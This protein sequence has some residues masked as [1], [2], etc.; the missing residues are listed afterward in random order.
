MKSKELDITLNVSIQLPRPINHCT[1]NSDVIT[2]H[3]ERVCVHHLLILIDGHI[4]QW[5]KYDDVCAVGM[6]YSCFANKLISTKITFSWAHKWFSNPIHTFISTQQ[7]IHFIITPSART[8]TYLLYNACGMLMIIFHESACYR[9]V[10]YTSVFPVYN[11][12]MTTNGHIKLPFDNYKLALEPIHIYQTI[13]HWHK[14]YSKFAEII[15]I[16]CIFYAMITLVS[17]QEYL[18]R[19]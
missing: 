9:T 18:K 1:T 14:M 2:R 15:Y 8:P 5:R 17:G 7:S 13:V 6:N 4:L 10:G 3:K 12:S 11:Y 16:S 19:Y